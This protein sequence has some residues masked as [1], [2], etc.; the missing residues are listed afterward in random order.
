[1]GSVLVYIDNRSVRLHSTF[2]NALAKSKIKNTFIHRQNKREYTNR[3][4]SHL[5][6]I[7]RAYRIRFVSTGES[8]VVCV[9]F[10]FQLLAGVARLCYPL[11]TIFLCFL[12]FLCCLCVPVAFSLALFLPSPSII[13]ITSKR[14]QK[15]SNDEA[16]AL[17]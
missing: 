11:S 4:D 16:V 8:V 12:F 9:V 1:M 5:K 3:F 7:L 6:I 10:F 17:Q 14:Q 13:A 15:Q 2:P